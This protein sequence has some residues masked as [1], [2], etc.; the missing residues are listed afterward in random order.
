MT[1]ERAQAAF[2]GYL[3]EDGKGRHPD[4]G[5][6]RMRG[7][8]AGWRGNSEP[9]VILSPGSA[10]LGSA[11]GGYSKARSESAATHLMLPPARSHYGR[12]S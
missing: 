12:M 6:N 10:L 1:G 8:P 4:C 7:V 11:T 9:V 5:Q 2:H 3:A